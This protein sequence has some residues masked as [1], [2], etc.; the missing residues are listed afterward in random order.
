MDLCV[1]TDLSPNS[2]TVRLSTSRNHSSRHVG[3]AD[4]AAAEGYLVDRKFW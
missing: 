4:F 3:S 1:S 2:L